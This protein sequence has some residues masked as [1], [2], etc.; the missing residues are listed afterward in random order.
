MFAGSVTD[1]RRFRLFDALKQQLRRYSDENPLL[2]V[3]DDCHNADPAS[4]LF[5][6]FV[7]RDLRKHRAMV[8]VTYRAAEVR[9][10]S[11][12]A[13]LLVDI[14][15]DGETIHLGGISET[16]VEKFFKS[17]VGRR[18]ESSLVRELHRVTEGN[19]F[20][21][22]E[23]TQSIN[24]AGR[25][26]QRRPRTIIDLKVPE[27]IRAT[28]LKRLDLLSAPA[29]SILLV[30]A[31]VGHEFDM[32]LLRHVTGIDRASMEVSIEEACQHAI[33]EEQGELSDRCR[34]L[35]AL[36]PET[37]YRELPRGERR[38]LHHK[39]AEAIEEVS[40]VDLEPHLSELAYHYFRAVT[41]ETATRVADYALRAA[42]AAQ[43]ILAYEEAA[44]LYGMALSA[45]DAFPRAEQRR[46]CE[47]MLLQGGALYS[48]GDFDQSRSVFKQ[49]AMIATDL[50]DARS[51]AVA[52]LGFGTTPSTPGV[53]DLS[54]IS[55]LE[56]ALGALDESD[57][58]LR[59]ALNGKAGRGTVLVRAICSTRR[60]V[61]CGR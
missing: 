42:A 39:I 11:V 3:L 36:I 32:S 24:S 31:V 29:R 30:A 58:P 22:G 20:F 14:G 12:W 47:L 1:N 34:F 50:G 25:A 18:P 7:S 43:K 54:F 4:L 37:L 35:H 16:D 57:T 59:V 5:L 17:R 53:A 23:L 41:A 60:F 52:V 55:M 44:R 48:S 40:S 56:G 21:L 15:R 49:A 6:K 46:R 51:R 2:L 33:L 27:G 61:I 8:L 38:R 19:P 45:I 26:G 28:I 13:P 9:M 10:S